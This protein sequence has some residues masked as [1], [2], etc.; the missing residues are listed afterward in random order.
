VALVLNRRVSRYP[1]N[2]LLIVMAWCLLVLCMQ[3]VLPFVRNWMTLM[4][5]YYA[6]ASAGLIYAGKSVA[7]YFRQRYSFKARLSVAAGSIL[8]VVLALGLSVMM[9]TAQ[10][11]YQKDE[12]GEYTRNTTRD[13]EEVALFL[14][15]KLVE[16]DIVFSDFDYTA[17]PLEY[18]F[19][20]YGIPLEYLVVN[21]PDVTTDPK[22]Q[23]GNMVEWGQAW[24]SLGYRPG[25]TGSIQRAFFIIAEDES[26][27]FEDSLDYAKQ[28]WGGLEIEDFYDNGY[29]VLDTGFTKLLVF[30]RKAE[31]AS[32]EQAQ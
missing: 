15:D 30:Y 28:E 19:I 26:H 23:P 3:R 4:P 11:A 12:M 21:V 8:A 6:G 29:T 20:K 9:V 13:A 31:G 24:N 7:G 10:T 18:Y 2:L 25:G 17:V 14:K 27:Y 32:V 22:W 1:V 16:G 5:L